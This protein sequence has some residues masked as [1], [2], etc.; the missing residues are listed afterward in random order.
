MHA[1]PGTLNLSAYS[2]GEIRWT[3]SV[4]LQLPTTLH[5]E[6]I[7]IEGTPQDA[8]PSALDPDCNSP[9]EVETILDRRGVRSRS[10]I[11]DG[12]PRLGT[13]LRLGLEI[14]AN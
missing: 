12:A 9:H 3:L 11:D 6:E 8:S 4:H 1:L 13:L 14:K 7:I 10:L 2:R 5:T